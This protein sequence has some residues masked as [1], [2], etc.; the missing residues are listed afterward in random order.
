MS[1]T[2][3]IMQRMD[4]PR[5]PLKGWEESERLILAARHQKPDEKPIEDTRQ[6]ITANLNL[7]EMEAC[8]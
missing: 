6:E 1:L 3:N 5:M 7:G 4:R 2:A 8:A